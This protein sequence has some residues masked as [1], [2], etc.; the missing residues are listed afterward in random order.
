VTIN[1]KDCSYPQN[2]DEDYLKV[3]WEAY[4]SGSYQLPTGNALWL[5]SETPGYLVTECN[6]DPRNVHLTMS[7]ASLYANSGKLPGSTYDFDQKIHNGWSTDDS[8]TSVTKTSIDASI[9]GLIEGFTPKVSASVANELSAASKITNEKSTDVEVQLNLD[10][11]N[12]VYLYQVHVSVD[13][14]G[15]GSIQGFGGYF[16]SNDPVPP[17]FAQ[18]SSGAH[19]QR[20][21][22]NSRPVFV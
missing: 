11:S 9:E 19:I 12:P 5:T 13:A 1:P 15:Y 6:Q 2:I 16:T 10:L 20:S 3:W 18:E 17:M 14:P 8:L 4:G 7:L 21:P 22:F